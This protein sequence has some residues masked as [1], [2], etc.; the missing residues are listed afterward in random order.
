VF[1]LLLSGAAVSTFG[2]LTGAL[3]AAPRALF[4]LARDGFLPRRLSDVHPR[5]RTPHIAIATFA[6]VAVALAVSG[7]F[8]RLVVV[9][10]LAAL[11]VYFMSAI[12]VWAMRLRGIRGEGEPFVIPG[13]ATVPV[14]ACAATAW[15]A[16]A[17]V[18]R[19][20]VAAF[21]FVIVVSILLY[22][23][24]RGVSRRGLAAVSS[25]GG[26]DAHGGLG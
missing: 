16:A 7:T 19:P 6:L 11:G 18:T 22:G 8:E 13:G 12:A 10:N 9:S 14:L 5:F 25:S 20:E 1:V 23:V 21:G 24:S 15:V 26:D 3:L 2:W 4:A 17:T